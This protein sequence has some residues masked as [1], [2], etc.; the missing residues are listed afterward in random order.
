[1]ASLIFQSFGVESTAVSAMLETI[2]EMKFFLR[3]AYGDSKTFA[4]SSIE[5]KTQGL[6]QGNGASPAGWCVISIVILRA[7]GAKGHGTHFMAPMSHVCPSLLAIL[8][9]DDTDLLHINMDAEESIVEVHTAIQRAIENWGRLLIATGGTLKPEKCN[10]HLIDFVWTQKGGWQYIAHYED[11]GAALFVPLP[12]G[13]MA[14]ISHLAVDDAQKT[15]GVT[16]CPFGNSTGSLHQ[17][18][19]KA[20]KWFDSLTAGRL[21]RRMMWFSDDRQMW[22]SAKYGLCCSMATLSELDSVLMPL[23]G[24]MLPLGGIVSK[25]NQCIRQLDRGFYGAGFSHPGVEATLEQAN[26]LLMHYGCRTAL[27]TELQNSLELLV[28]DLGLSF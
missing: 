12:D 2:Q 5:I 16:T 22:P 28:V 20:K 11:E 8:Y 23:Y 9:V 17:M 21:H 14:L 10:Y 3:M 13:E 4:G 19:G 6:G 26:K 18:K 7:H 27:G 15:L 1:M 24:K 25:A